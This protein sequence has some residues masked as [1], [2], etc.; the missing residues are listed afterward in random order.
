[1]KVGTLKEQ[2][3]DLLR[4]QGYDFVTACELYDRA[5][6][7]GLF[8]NPGRVCVGT[9]TVELAQGGMAGAS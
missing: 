3:V 8:D 4:E 5:R 9:L 7:D 2:I 6:S 1:M